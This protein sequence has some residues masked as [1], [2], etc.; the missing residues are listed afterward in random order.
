MI[1]DP[2]TSEVCG[3]REVGE[4]VVRG[5]SVSPGYF[6]EREGRRRAQLHTGD[7]GYIASGRLYVIGRLKD[8]IIMAGQNYAPSDIEAC[9]SDAPGLEGGAPRRVLHAG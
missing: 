3:E 4:I 8:L 1:I 7:L 2:T 9:V 5:P 6:G